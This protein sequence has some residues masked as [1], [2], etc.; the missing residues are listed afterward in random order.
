[1]GDDFKIS[2][3]EFAR[4]IAFAF[5]GLPFSRD[6]SWAFPQ[7]EI[8]RSGSGKDVVILGA[9]L[10]GL[11]AGWEL[12]KAGHH[13][14]ILEAQLHPGG[15]VHT[16]REG[17]SDDLYAEAGAGRIPAN[18][19]VTLEWVKYFG[20]ELEPFYPK[21]LAQI[22]SLKGKRV[23]LPADKP[24]DMSLVPARSDEVVRRYLQAR[25]P[26]LVCR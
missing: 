10:A 17:L 21:D 6:L 12:Q 2:R 18:H 7:Q 26:H 24:V 16:I 4:L 9:G 25:R 23:K 11:V 3:R 8:E 5:G 14:T 1:V 15:R 13:V 19:E 20:L 22:A